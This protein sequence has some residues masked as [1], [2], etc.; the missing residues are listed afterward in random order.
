MTYVDQST[1]VIQGLSYV[2]PNTGH[3]I[4]RVDNTTNIPAGPVVSRNSVRNSF[5]SLLD[6]LLIAYI[7]SGQAHQ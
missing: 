5:H 2:D 7:S 3:A 4:I 6:S 1:A